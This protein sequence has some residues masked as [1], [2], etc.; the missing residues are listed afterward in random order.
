MISAISAPW[1]ATLTPA[2]HTLTSYFLVIAALALSVGIVRTTMTMGEVG[3]RYR[4]AAIARLGVL[5][6]AFLSYLLLVINFQFGYE[7]TDAGYVPTATSITTFLPRYMEWTVSVP[8]LTIELLAVCALVGERLRRTRVIAAT[9]ALLMIFAG[10]L[11]LVIGEGEDQGQL[12]IWGAVSCVFWILTNV[13]LIRAVRASLPQLTPAAAQLLRTATILLL[14]GWIIYPAVYTVQIFAFGGQWTTTMQVALSLADVIVKLGFG[15]LVHRIAKLRTAEDVRAGVDIHAE[16]IWISSEKVSDAGKP[17]EVFLAEG[18]AIH[19]R[20]E[21]QTFHSVA[22]PAAV[23][24]SATN[25][26][27]PE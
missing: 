27:D 24:D 1:T 11:G 20:R 25:S 2:Q 5:T 7:L 18:A 10:F 9:G 14:S 22:S 6:V 21:P 17:S 13:V 15:G 3:P 19:Q 12:I 8:L 4:T 26:V 23:D 16:S